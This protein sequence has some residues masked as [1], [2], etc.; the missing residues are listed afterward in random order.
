MCSAISSKVAMI[1]M[2]IGIF[3]ELTGMVTLFVG[4]S[5]EGP[6]FTAEKYN[7]KF[8]VIAWGYSTMI[9]GVSVLTI[10]GIIMWIACLMGLGPNQNGKT[11]YDV[12]YNVN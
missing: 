9:F 5:L 7:Y 1:I 4:M 3:F 10:G 11:R 2:G 6:T 8:N 12:S